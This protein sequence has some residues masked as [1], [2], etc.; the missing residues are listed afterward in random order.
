MKKALN[1][2]LLACASVVFGSCNKFSNGDVTTQT[3]QT[4]TFQIVEMC[5][6]VDVTLKHCDAQNPAG[7]IIITTGENLIDNIGTEIEEIRISVTHNGVNDTLVFNKLV[8]TNDNNLNFLRPYD[9]T[10]ETTVYYDSLFE[11]IFNSNA[12]IITDTLRGYNYWTNFN[13]QSDTTIITA[14]SLRPNILL[15][16]I[17][18]SGDFTVLTNCFR[19]MTNY[20]HG[21][22]NLI[23][24]GHAVRAETYGD[25]DCHG[26]IDGFDMEADSYHMVTALGTNKIIARAFNQIIAQ[27]DNIGHVYYVRYS[28]PGKIIHWGHHEG[29]HWVDND[30]I[31]T[32][33]SCPLSVTKR[34]VYKD[35]ITSVHDRPWP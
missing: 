27:N 4:E 29:G 9:Y 18:G 24:K 20:I 17:G 8:I 3:R 30:T 23:L 19:L 11:L 35:S 33:Y 21:T 16:V 25:Y 14:D 13:N 32:L 12:T 22:S 28:K 10:L 6:N 15:S 7:T 26:V 34:G 1:V 5:D 2:L 31:D